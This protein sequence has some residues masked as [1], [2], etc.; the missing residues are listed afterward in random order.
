MM[1]DQ[2]FKVLKKQKL[3]DERYCCIEK[4]LVELEN[5]ATADWFLSISPDAAIVIP[6]LPN[7]EILIQSQ[8][9]HGSGKVVTEFCA[10]IIEKGETPLLGAQRELREETGHTSTKWHFLGKVLANPTSSSM[11]Y[12]YF[13]AEDCRP[14]SEQDLDNAEQSIQL[15]TVKNTEQALEI[16]VQN[17][18]GN[19]NFAALTLWQQYKKRTP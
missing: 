19:T 7:G 18:S 16:F 11:H 2:P 10:G 3:V 14:T 4:Q 9:K 17:P 15:K 8:Y 12:H 13:W 6:T 5:G 1:N